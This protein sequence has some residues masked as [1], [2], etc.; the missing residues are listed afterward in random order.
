MNNIIQ[1][2]AKKNT[3]FFQHKC[4]FKWKIKKISVDIHCNRRKLMYS[5]R[6]K[7]SSRMGVKS[8]FAIP[9]KGF[10]KLVDSLIVLCIAGGRDRR[11]DKPGSR[12]NLLKWIPGFFYFH[13]LECQLCSGFSSRFVFHPKGS[14]NLFFINEP[15][16]KNCKMSFGLG[17]NYWKK[18]PWFS[19]QLI[20]LQ[21]SPLQFW[22][23]SVWPK[24]CGRGHGHLMNLLLKFFRILLA[25]RRTFRNLKV[26]PVGLM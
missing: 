25:S 10:R 2:G 15:S 3:S 8:V 26:F 4:G 11:R 22:G 16:V 9:G 20:C 19:S 17:D 6:H 1:F 18:N 14:G 7:F 13:N 21:F 23:G 12:E 24:I 5:C